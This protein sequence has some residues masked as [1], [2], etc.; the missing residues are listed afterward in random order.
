MGIRLN[1]YQYCIWQ[2]LI[3]TRIVESLHWCRCLYHVDKSLLL[4]EIVF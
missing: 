2:K 4:D 3:L 1:G